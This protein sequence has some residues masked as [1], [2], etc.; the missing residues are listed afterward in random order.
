MQYY[1]VIEKRHYETS[2]TL[3]S[4]SCGG[5]SKDTVLRST[6]LQSSMQGMI[7]KRPGPTAP[8]FIWCNI[9]NNKNGWEIT[10]L[11]LPRRKITA[12]S[13]SWITLMQKNMETGKVH[14]K[15]MTEMMVRKMVVQLIQISVSPTAS[16][17]FL[18]DTMLFLFTIGMT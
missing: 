5:T 2:L 4:I 18:S 13:Y 9:K 16:S 10:F 14:T 1:A 3:V 15:R 7:K 8:P 6:T 17:D 12:R 11:T